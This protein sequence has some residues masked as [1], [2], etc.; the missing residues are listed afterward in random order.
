MNKTIHF[1][2]IDIGKGKSYKNNKVFNDCY[3]ANKKK[4]P[5]YKIKLWN[6]EMIEE[7]INKYPNYK[8]MWD[9]FPHQFY[10]VDFCRYMFLY[11]EGGIYCDL[12]V[13]IDGEID[14]TKDY[15]LGYW[16][17]PENTSEKKYNNN[18]IYFKN[19]NIYKELMDFCYERY[20]KC[21]MPI[22]WTS[23][24]MRYTV[25]DRCFTSFLK[26]K[27]IKE[28]DDEYTIPIT[29]YQLVSWY[30]LN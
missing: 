28:Y 10:K 5:D 20:E 29:D 4:H 1:V 3:E 27:N 13:I 19:K 25:G 26:T 22:S 17:N 8:K 14:L 2:F 9:S 18:L 23:R 15:L 7:L 16:T 6:E 24:R 11:H 30:P 12:D 21:K